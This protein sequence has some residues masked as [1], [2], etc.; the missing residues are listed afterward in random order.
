MNVDNSHGDKEI[1]TTTLYELSKNFLPC[2]LRNCRTVDYCSQSSSS[3]CSTS[4]LRPTPSLWRSASLEQIADAL[5]L[6]GSWTRPAVEENFE[7][8]CLHGTWDI[9]M[10]YHEPSTRENPPCNSVDCAAL[11]EKHLIP[12]YEYLAIFHLSRVNTLR[13]S[14]T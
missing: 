7:R 12:D 2:D 5:W 6:A 13:L 14:L 8:S 10:H 11:L 4:S 3:D 1:E 9:Q